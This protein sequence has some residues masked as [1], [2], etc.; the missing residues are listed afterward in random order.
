VACDAKLE[1]ARGALELVESLKPRILGVGTG[2]TVARFIGLLDAGR[3]EGVAASSVVS[4]LELAARGFRVLSPYTVASVDV[5]VDGADEVDPGGNMVKGRGAALLGEKVLASASRVNIF[6]VGED[7]LVDV[8]GSRR[9]VPVEVVRDALS[10]VLARLRGRWPGAAPRVGAG[11]D[12][13]V[14]SDWGG[15]IVDVPTGPLEDPWEA[16]R[17]MR[18]IPGVVETG[19]FLG[20][21]DYV[22]VGRKSCGWEVLRFERGGPSGRAPA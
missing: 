6:I 14:V 10:S 5:Y 15:V 7:K 12:G 3:F 1:A 21:A 4:G 22:V 11:K 8:L 13:P 17:F 16:E 18:S 19:L 20:V 9:P 2:S